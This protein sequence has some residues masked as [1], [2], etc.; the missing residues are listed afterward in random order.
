MSD[1]NRYSLSTNSNSPDLRDIIRRRSKTR[2]GT[3]N[4]NSPDLRDIIR[5]RSE[6]ITGTRNRGASPKQKNKNASPSKSDGTDIGALPIQNSSCYET[7]G[8]NKDTKLTERIILIIDD[9][10][11]LPL[12]I[13]GKLYNSN[14]QKNN[15]LNDLGYMTI[16]GAIKKDDLYKPGGY[17][18]ISELKEEYGITVNDW[19]NKLE[20]I[21]TGTRN[22]CTVTYYMIN[23]ALQ[24]LKFEEATDA[25]DSAPFSL[26]HIDNDNYPGSYDELTNKLGNDLSNRIKN[27]NTP[28]KS[29]LHFIIN[30]SIIYRY[31]DETLPDTLMQYT[32]QLM[33]NKVISINNGQS[34]LIKYNYDKN[35]S[36]DDETN[37]K[38][39]NESMFGYAD[40]RWYFYDNACRISYHAYDKK[41]KLEVLY[42]FKSH[43]NENMRN[44][45]INENSRKSK[46]FSA[47]SQ[48]M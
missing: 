33:G 10:I 36:E 21:Y 8:M 24:D 39:I 2:T 19:K 5:G 22:N 13:K 41:K 34:Y 17:T 37:L 29:Y 31:S 44:F 25:W 14:Y 9:H 1:N 6:T 30:D 11:F 20:P 26:Y 48:L 3:T 35:V 46:I 27:A 42:G 38:T 43:I 28:C 23:C 18:C 4:S 16:G 7:R 12:N 15:S 47:L 40:N 45:D 32:D